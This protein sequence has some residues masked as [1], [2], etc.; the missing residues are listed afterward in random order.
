MNLRRY[1][2]ATPRL[3]REPPDCRPRDYFV[4]TAS[5]ALRTSRASIPRVLRTICRLCLS[6]N[7]CCSAKYSLNR[8]QYGQIEWSFCR[9]STRGKTQRRY[10][11]SHRFMLVIFTNQLRRK[12]SRTRKGYKR[13]G[14]IDLPCQGVWVDHLSNSTYPRNFTSRDRRGHTKVRFCRG[15]VTEAVLLDWHGCVISLRPLASP[16]YELELSR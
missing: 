16:P 3:R 12:T 1:S 5:H 6:D 10:L 7:F 13:Q 2:V 9:G 15:A 11:S 4:P 14:S 8:S